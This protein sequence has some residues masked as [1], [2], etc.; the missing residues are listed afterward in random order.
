M[1]VQGDVYE[2][3]KYLNKKHCANS[4]VPS[5]FEVTDICNNNLLVTWIFCKLEMASFHSPGC[6]KGNQVLARR[7]VPVI[8]VREKT[9]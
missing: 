4:S 5:I 6:M 3:Y 9:C 8:P 2:V 1:N 7:R